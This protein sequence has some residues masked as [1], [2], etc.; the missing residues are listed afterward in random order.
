[1][2]VHGVGGAL[3]HAAHH[4]SFHHH[5]HSARTQKHSRREIVFVKTA[6]AAGGVHGALECMHDLCTRVH[7]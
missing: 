3:C 5:V 1:M 7:A 6:R 4:H 2:H